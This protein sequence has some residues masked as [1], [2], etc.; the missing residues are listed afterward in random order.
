MFFNVT[1]DEGSDVASSSAR[2]VSG[3][4]YGELIK[5]LV[6]NLDRFLVLGLRVGGVRRYSLHDIESRHYG[7][8]EG[9]WV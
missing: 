9:L 2:L 7:K 4:R 5:K 1:V 8:V 6:K 3:L